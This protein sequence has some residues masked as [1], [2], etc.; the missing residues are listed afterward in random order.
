MSDDPKRMLEASRG[1]LRA[2]LEAGKSE[3]PSDRQMMM[4]AAKI[5]ILGGLG[6]AGAAGAAGAGG[7]GGAGAGASAGAGAGA[8]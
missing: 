2:L 5:G 3:V 1:E 8:G 4:L 6:G 7:A